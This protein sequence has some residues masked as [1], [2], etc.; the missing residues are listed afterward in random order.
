MHGRKVSDISNKSDV[1]S[2]LSDPF[3]RLVEEHILDKRPTKSFV[4]FATKQ[5]DWLSKQDDCIKK[6]EIGFD[7]PRMLSSMLKYA[8]MAG[9]EGA[10][11]YAACAIVTCDHDQYDHRLLVDLAETW[12]TH[13]IYPCM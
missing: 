7:W 12:L 6:S 3:K 8:E 4:D 11:R 9:G 13:F 1:S 10:K 2:V 5:I